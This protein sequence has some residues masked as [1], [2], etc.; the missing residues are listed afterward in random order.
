MT[1]GL[2]LIT[3][4]TLSWTAQIACV[5]FMMESVG[6]GDVKWPMVGHDESLTKA[7]RVVNFSRFLRL[8]HNASTRQL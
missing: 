6:C 3:R 4:A 7:L 8:G 1:S 2:P 5:E